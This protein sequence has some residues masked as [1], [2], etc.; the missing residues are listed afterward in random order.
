MTAVLCLFIASFLAYANG[1]NDNFKGV[2]TL[3]GSGKTSFPRA[4]AWGTLATFLGSLTAVFFAQKLLAAF[5]G[6]GLGRRPVRPRIALA[7]PSRV[8][9]GVGLVSRCA[10]SSPDACVIRTA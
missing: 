6:A 9:V 2:A 7:S 1:A 10:A 3:F 4:L 8:G 5:S